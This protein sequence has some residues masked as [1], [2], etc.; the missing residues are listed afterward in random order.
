MINYHIDTS[1]AYELLHN[2]ILAL[3]KAEMQG[4]RLDE[5]YIKK[6]EKEISAKIVELE[7][8][9][10][11]S[12]FYKKWKLSQTQPVNIYSPTQ[13][14]KYLYKTRG[15]KIKKETKSG[16]GSTDDEALRLLNIP[17][18]NILLEIKKLKKMR[19]TYLAQF[20]REVVDG[21][22]HPFFNLH[23]VRTFRSSSDSPNFQN[24]PKRDT[25]AMQTIRKAIYPR[26]GHQL[27]E[28]DYSQLEVRIAACYSK[29]ETLINDILHGD[30]HRDMA[31]EL[32][33]IKKFDKSVKWHG[34]LRQAAKNGF[35][36]PQFYGDYYKNCAENL[37]QNWGKLPITGK[38]KPGQGIELIDGKHLS[39]HLI[40]QKLP[41][42]KK[43]VEHVQRIEGYFWGE[44]YYTHAKWRDSIWNEYQKNGYITSYTGVTF[45]D[46]MKRNDVTNY[47]V[48]GAAFHCLLWALIMGT[49]AL[50]REK[51][52]TVIVGQIH[53]AIVLDVNPKELE[54]V[55]KIMRCIM[56]HDVVKHWPWI[57]VPLDI[58]AELCPVDGSWAEK[59]EYK[60]E[61][62]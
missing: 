5:K 14:S 45:Q 3:Q 61:K 17:E 51:M 42:Y 60:I 39:D 23:T 49:Q 62:L 15:L 26:K 48:Q 4:L 20:K 47:P 24:I 16:Q 32:Y 1:D 30:M 46:I 28:L 37:I 29:D 11:K 25:E 53:D 55:I 56:V 6:T 12:G 57:I 7:K 9:I 33:K 43:F 59:Q 27:L 13:L 18:L 41:S 52:D 44:R 34:V 54:K 8:Q 40:E 19:D 36:F 10:E 21:I 38:W 35:V 50:E 58:G 22:I 2:G 31:M